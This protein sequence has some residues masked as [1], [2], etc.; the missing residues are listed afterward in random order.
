M[1]SLKKVKVCLKVC[2]YVAQYNIW[3]DPVGPLKALY[4]FPLLADLFIPTP[5]QLLWDVILISE[6]WLVC[7]PV[8]DS[9]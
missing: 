2:F 1:T 3:N 6:M 4:A 8:M 9:Q 7:A 5:T